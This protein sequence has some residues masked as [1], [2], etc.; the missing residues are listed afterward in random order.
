MLIA[1]T[2]YGKDRR[3]IIYAIS[4][5]LAEMNVNIVDIEQRVLHGIFLIF[6][7]THSCNLEIFLGIQFHNVQKR[8][9][10]KR[11]LVGLSE[12]LPRWQLV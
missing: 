1:V 6:L 2:V 12:N 3:G 11:M 9:W 7:I 8:E 4:N 10:V 5:A